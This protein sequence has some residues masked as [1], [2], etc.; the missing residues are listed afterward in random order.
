MKIT[1]KLLVITVPV[2][3]KTY[4]INLKKKNILGT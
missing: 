1:L 4:L 2:K 3:R